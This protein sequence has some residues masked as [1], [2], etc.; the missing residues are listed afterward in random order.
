MI[1]KERKILMRSNACRD[2]EECY[3]K[4][5]LFVGEEMDVN[6]K[7]I[8]EKSFTYSQDD[9]HFR[10]SFRGIYY[11][12]YYTINTDSITVEVRD[13][14]RNQRVYLPKETIPLK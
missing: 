12:L 1:E 10:G 13:K 2:Q 4:I 5:N 8:F 9:Y 3:V 14:F 6:K 7:P 11:Y